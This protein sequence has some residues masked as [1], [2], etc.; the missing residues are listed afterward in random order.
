[1]VASALPSDGIC[2]LEVNSVSE[3]TSAGITPPGPIAPPTRLSSLPPLHALNA[4]KAAATKNNFNLPISLGPLSFS[5]TRCDVFLR[6]S[7]VSA[8]SSL[9]PSRR[10]RGVTNTKS[11][12]L[13]LVD[14]RVRNKKPNPGMSPK[15]GTLLTVSRVSVS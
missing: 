10:I 3:P 15:S 4:A 13:L 2:G 12:A 9:A 7:P 5:T 1:M 14:V 11:S 8:Y 6:P